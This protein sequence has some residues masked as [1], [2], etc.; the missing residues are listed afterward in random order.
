[1][2]LALEMSP[3]P[4]YVATARTWDRNFEDRILRHIA[5]RSDQWVT[6]EVEKEI[7][8]IDL[9]GKVAVVDCVTLW[10]TNFF[11]DNQQNIEDS[12]AQAKD[13]FDRLS[14]QDGTFIVV[15]NEIGMGVH[16]PT[17]SGRK[18]ADLQGRMNQ[19]IAGKSDTVVLM[20]AGIAVP[21]KG[22]LQR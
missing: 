2:R 17:E 18:F 16:A 7:G 10:L 1:M 14:E 8:N 4:T 11:V 5:D 9:K 22:S 19:Y 6:L 15:S 12:F 20:V 3:C 13:Q 21:V